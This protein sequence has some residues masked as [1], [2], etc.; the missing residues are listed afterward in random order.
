MN[1]YDIIADD[2]DRIFPLDEEL[3]AFVERIFPDKNG[4]LI[5]AGCATGA[6]AIA[7]AEDG[8]SVTG[9]DSDAR[10]I[11]KAKEKMRAG[12]KAEFKQADMAEIGAFTGAAGVLCFGNTL[13]H[14]PDEAAVFDFFKSVHGALADNGT[15]VFE[16]LNYDAILSIKDFAFKDIPVGR[17]VFKR[18]YDCKDENRITFTAG[19]F[20]TVNGESDFSSVPLLPLRKNVLL[21]LLKDADLNP[22]AFENFNGTQCE[23]GEFATTYICSR[24]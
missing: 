19:L 23:G 24:L 6:L 8:Y 3:V 17:F 9:L 2:Y 22:R 21:R 14:L 5:D 1:L 20:D 10:M 18:S 15:F 11:A 13:P 16:L 4:V 7:L 12:L